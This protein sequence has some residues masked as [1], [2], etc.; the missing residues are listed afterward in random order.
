[1][2]RYSGEVVYLFA[3]DIAYEMSREPV[4]EIFGQQP[5]PFA[6]DASKHAPRQLFSYRPRMFKLPAVE[7]TGPR[8][9][10]RLD[11]SLKILQVGAISISVRMPFEADRLED[12]V[13]CHDLKLSNGTLSEHI[14]QIAENVRKQLLPYLNR[15][16]EKLSEAEAYTVFCL[17]A[18]LPLDAATG[19]PMGAEPWLQA[20]RRSIAAL[21][22]QESD[23]QHLSEQ[24]ALESTGRFLSYYDHDLVVMDWDAA[25]VVDQAQFFDET[26]YILELANL[27]LAELKAYD[28]HLDDA[29]D[30]SYRDLAASPLRSRQKMLRQLQEICV[31]M[32]RFSDEMS[33]I[34]KF[35]GD[36]H[37]ARVY[38][39][40][41]ARFHLQDW[42]K[43]VD[44]KLRTLGELYDMLQNEQNHRWIMILEVG[45][46]LLFILDLIL[47]VIVK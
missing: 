13:T 27:H 44:E 32:A 28:R 31:D 14:L 2:A 47:L 38:E 42:S 10:L 17:K 1:M 15:P 4:R 8:G 19:N 39:G 36:W 12:L 33:N 26:L 21:L 7:K 40:I 3:Y 43:I 20:H 11:C 22:T 6:I 5:T 46:V 9:P 30:R 24:E 34:T 25:L 45:M 23:A 18:P 16:V 29:L 35:F 37:L 41:A